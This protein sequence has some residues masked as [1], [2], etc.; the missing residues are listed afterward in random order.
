MK[1]LL[2]VLISGI[3]IVALWLVIAIDSWTA[4]SLNWKF[5]LFF[6]GFGSAAVL[7]SFRIKRHWTILVLPFSFLL[8]IMIVPFVDL[9]AVKPAIR[10]LN[11]VSTGMTETQVRLIFE[12]EYRAHTRYKHPNIR[13]LQKGV[14]SFVVDSADGCC[15]AAI[16]RI[17][18]SDGK[19]IAKEF[20]PD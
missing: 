9:T 12:E 14:L 15:D 16:I 17:R 1:T 2:T 13:E 8:F 6:I 20:L 18:F 7:L 19:C 3:L 5:E 4:E 11:R 10:A